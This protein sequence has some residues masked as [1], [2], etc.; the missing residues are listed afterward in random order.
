[1]KPSK[2]LNEW[3]LEGRTVSGF[4]SPLVGAV[5]VLW[6]HRQVG[7]RPPLRCRGGLS[8]VSLVGLRDRLG[9][10]HTVWV[11]WGIGGFGRRLLAPRF[12]SVRSAVTCLSPTI[13][14]L[15]A[16]K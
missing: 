9:G 12:P 10:G 7:R 8:T 11:R 16:E 2:G 14:S 13:G 5:G 3:A 1:V 6:Y 15:R 4:G